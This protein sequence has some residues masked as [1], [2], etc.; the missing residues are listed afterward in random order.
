LKRVKKEHLER[1]YKIKE[2]VDEYDFLVQLC[3]LSG[4]LL[5][6]GEPDLTTAA[7]MVLHDW[8]RGKI[9]FFVPP[10]KQDDVADIPEK[11]KD[12]VAEEN[13]TVLAA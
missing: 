3:K 1:A 7:K 9:P 13:S 2:W 10:P 5:R 11:V 12:D 6:G 8:Q 4:K